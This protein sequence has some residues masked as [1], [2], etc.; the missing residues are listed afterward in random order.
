[1]ELKKINDV[2]VQL[3]ADTT[4]MLNMALSAQQQAKTMAD[5]LRHLNDH[6]YTYYDERARQYGHLVSQ[7]TIYSNLEDDR[8]R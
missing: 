2:T 8:E 5:G 1:M 4:D 3:T 7:L 6:M